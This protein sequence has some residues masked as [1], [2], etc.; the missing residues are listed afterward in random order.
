MGQKPY[1]F[2]RLS[3]VLLEKLTGSPLVKKFPAFYGTRKFITALTSAR[4]L[5]LSW[6]NSIQSMHPRPISWKSILQLFSHLH[7]VLPSGLFPS[8]FPTKLLYTP[9]LSPYV[10]HAPPISFFNWWPKSIL[11]GVQIIKLLVRHSSLLPCYLVAPKP[12]YSPQRPIL[13]HPQPSPLPQCERPSCTPIQNNR[14][15][16]SSVNL[17]LYS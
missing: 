3:S 6:A 16:Y 12:K 9:L 7:L 15:S 13:K 1:L 17:N 2:I 11:W 14:Q 8:G 4:H 10:L 5:S